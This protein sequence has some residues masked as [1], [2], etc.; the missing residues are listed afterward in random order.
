M[1]YQYLANRLGSISSVKNYISGARTWVVEHGGNPIGFSGN[2]Q[3]MMIKSLTKDSTHQVKRAF[4]LTL[5]HISVIASYLGSARNAPRCIKPCILIGYSCYLRSSNLV[6]PSFALYGGS[7]SLLKKHVID[8]G[9][10]LDVTIASTKTRTVP[11]CILIPS[12]H[13]V[14]ICPVR[15]WRS[16]VAHSNPSPNAP[17]FM[18]D[19]V[20]P[21]TSA[22]VVRIMKDA[23]RGFPDID[24]STITMHSLRRGA[25]QQAARNG[26]ALTQIMDRGGW[27]STSGLRPYLSK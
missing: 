12:L 21:L 25:A 2:E 9:D 7:H 4:P 15:A 10:R 6:S 3:S 23:L 16:Y 22:L 26:A 27:S 5:E 1:F 24:S 20:T 8:R 11:Y 17:A 13:D 18:V 14:S 19:A